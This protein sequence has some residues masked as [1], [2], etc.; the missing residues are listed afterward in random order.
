M[1]YRWSRLG[2]Q[3]TPVARVPSCH[4]KTS[5]PAAL[6]RIR[7]QND[8]RRRSSI[9]NLPCRKWPGVSLCK[10]PSSTSY[11]AAGANNNLGGDAI[12]AAEFS[13][14]KDSNT[15]GGTAATT[16]DSS[17]NPR[18]PPN[19]LAQLYSVAAAF[20]ARTFRFIVVNVPRRLRQ[21]W[22]SNWVS[23]LA[24]VIGSIASLSLRAAGVVS[25][26]P[27]EVVY[28]QFLEAVDSKVV[29]AVRFDDATQRVYFDTTL[30][31]GATSPEEEVTEGTEQSPSHV[32]R[33]PRQYF[34]KRIEDPT[35]VA[36]LAAAGVEF[37]AMRATLTGAMVRTLGTALALWIPLLPLVFIMR[38]AL[39]GNNKN[40]AK[41]AGDRP[42]SPVVTFRDVAG[43]EA[44]KE[45]LREVVA[46]L[47]DSRRYA[48]LN[49]RMPS[50]V[51]L[52]GSPGTGKTLLA[53]A[54]AGEAG[55]PF[56]AASASEFVE[57]FVG[58]GAARIRDLF[59]QA[60]K[61]SPCVVF[62]DELD[63]VGGKRGIGMNEERDQT[64]NQLLTELDGFEG[65][66][67]ILFLAA[68][69]RP[70][71]LDPA[72]TRPGRLS[73]KVMV[74]LPDEAGRAAILAVHLRDTPLPVETDRA[75]LCTLVARVS[76]GLSG[77]ELANVVNEAALLAGRAGKEAID[78][79]DL[80]EGVQRTR[81]GVNGGGSA[82]MV[83]LGFRRKV[84][85]WFISKASTQQRM[86]ASP[87][88][89]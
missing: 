55:V 17:N 65:R 86:N 61:K 88:G 44:A 79:Q 70:E 84:Q 40:R 21:G 29:R 31:A 54:V 23:L 20:F 15:L 50:G 30:T 18:R 45:E 24:I 73:R 83:G 38:R 75:R 37:G 16:A 57:M 80:L 12:I 77:A 2:D 87:M 1:R 66:D 60:R 89:Q 36:K 11:T 78:L 8:S 72:L 41:K 14:A 26:P 63:A 64:L 19:P 35:L 4:T 68:T 6:C 81:Y 43:V 48:R 53:K 85:D 62:I 5:C 47:K 32:N 33:L 49:A 46:C 67:G 9:S 51:L 74:P 58:R 34:A 28:S 39:N 69:N 59:A 71:V 82:L 56:F 52:C 27:Q 10:V 22:K 25:R 42:S 7:P 76:R 13:D 3:C